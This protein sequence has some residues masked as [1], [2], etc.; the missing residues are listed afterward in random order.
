MEFYPVAADLNEGCQ[1][2]FWAEPGRACVGVRSGLHDAAAM[3][4]A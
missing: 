4:C 1:V 2:V 3:D